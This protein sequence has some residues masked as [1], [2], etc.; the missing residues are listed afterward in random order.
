MLAAD[1]FC[2]GKK[3]LGKLFATT[4]PKT[5]KQLQ[6]VVGKLNHCSPF[7]TDYKRKVKPLIDL[8]GKTG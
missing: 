2:L 4:L 1:R 8:L 3:A 6:S 7:V 5:L